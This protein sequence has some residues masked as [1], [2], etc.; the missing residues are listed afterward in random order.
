MKADALNGLKPAAH[1]PQLGVLTTLLALVAS[2]RPPAELQ[3]GRDGQRCA[4]VL[5]KLQ[6]AAPYA[7]AHDSSTDLP[8]AQLWPT[9]YLLGWNATVG[10]MKMENNSTP[11]VSQ[12]P[13]EPMIHQ[14]LCQ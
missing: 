7:A 13:C 11:S 1:E 6:A 14:L 10:T 4:D 8:G 3:A 2:C 9:R 12:W 5:P